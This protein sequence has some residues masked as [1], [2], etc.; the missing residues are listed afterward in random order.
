MPFVFY[1]T[2]TTGKHTSFDQILQFGAIRTNDDLEIEDST[3]DVINVR[4]RRLPHVVPSPKALQVT[5]TACRALDEARLS[6]YEMMREIL[7]RLN[8]WAPAIF[9]GYNSIKFDEPLLR[10][11]F[12]QNLLPVYRT[13]THGCCRG[14][15]MLMAQA[16]AAYSPADIIIPIGDKG[17]QVFKLGMVVR[18]NGIDFDEEDAHDALNDVK[19]T[20]ELARLIKRKAPVVWSTMIRNTRKHEANTF[21]ANN[22]VFCL[23]N[24]FFGKQHTEIAT[25]AGRNPD[26]SSEIATFD[27][28]NS[29]TAYLKLTVEG[30]IGILAQSPKIIR[31]VKTNS[32]PTLMSFA[33][34]PPATKAPWLG[35]DLYRQRAHMIKDNKGF[36][37]RVSAA[38][39]GRR[40]DAEASPYV[41]GQI[42][43]GFPTD[44][45]ESLQAEYHQ[46]P[47]SKRPELCR[48][49]SDKRLR[50]LGLRLVYVEH[51]EVLSYK[52]RERM[53]RWLAERLLNESEVPWTTVFRALIDLEDMKLTAISAE[54]RR[55]CKEIEN[56]LHGIAGTFDAAAGA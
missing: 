17:N 23:T 31:V 42:Y 27:L 7:G 48:Q 45:D 35:D 46:I 18:A 6:H 16:A 51:P 37:E 36:Q 24:F 34:R 28:S 10:Q 54:E 53:N 8:N 49:F 30:L 4:C 5:H 29:P 33:S 11:A 50:E 21:L 20:I 41:E 15:L 43:D 38:L 39:K 52:D 14:D 19:A 47:W 9:L 22:D 2:E 13:N 44:G 55:Q 32:Q 12:F 40:D 56:Y 3:N 26:N 1:D 25:M